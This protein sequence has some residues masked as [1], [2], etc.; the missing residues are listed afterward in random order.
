MIKTLRL[1][2]LF[3]TLA[4][5]VT[6]CKKKFDDYYAVPDGL[7]DPIYQTLQAKGNFKHYLAL[8]DRAGY[9]DILS[10]TGWF[11]VFAPDDAAFTKYFTDSGISTDAAISDSL[12]KG[13]VKFSLV[14]NGYR[15]DQLNIYQIAGTVGNP[16]MGYKR[17]TTYYDG[18]QQ[19][20]DAVH[21]KIIATNRNNTSDGKVTTVRYVDGDNNNKYIP[22][23]TDVFM[24]TNGLGASDYN[25]FYPNSAYS[26]FNVCGANVVNSDIIASN[27][28][29]HEIDRV[30]T[31]LPSIDQY[32]RLNANYSDFKLLMDSLAYYVA[33][34]NL[35]HANSV[36]TGSADSVYVKSYDGRLAYCIN[37]ENY[38]SGGS[39]I[40]TASQAAGWSILVPNNTALRAYRQKIL[41]KFGNSFFKTAPASVVIDFVNSLMWPSN[42][43]PSQFTLTNNYQLEPA[44][45][46]MGSI[47]DKQ[48]L[49]NGTFYGATQSQE[50]N[51]FRTVY[52]VQ[53]LDPK[54]SI[55]LQAYSS[56]ALP[57]KSQTTQPGVKNTVILMNDDVL[58]ANGWRY[59][60]AGATSATTT[61]WG[62][63]AVGST[64][65]SQSAVYRDVIFRMFQTGVLPNIDLTSLTGTGIV[66]TIN[67][68]FIKYNNGKIQ[69]S[70][71]LDAGVDL[72]VTQTNKT[73]VNGTAY[74]VDGML[75]FTNNNVGY[76]LQKLAAQYPSTY[77]SFYYYL[78][79]APNTLYN[80]TTQAI[81]GINTG[82]D[83]NYTVL[84]P[85]NAAITQAIKDGML[86]G[87][88]TTGA[89]PTAAPSSAADLDLVRK[90][91]L[92]HIINGSSLA[93]DQKTRQD[94]YPTL[95]QNES[96][97]TTFVGVENAPTSMTVI[98]R[99][100]KYI[101]VIL[102]A[103]SNQ[104]SNRTIIHS[105]DKYLHY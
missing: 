61:A 4:L 47:V 82:V 24:A 6:S 52:G 77:S 70:G 3:L 95:L 98:D 93:V 59:Y 16:G 60:E 22:Y 64:S 69:T 67:H 86:P 66:E 25:A 35:T 34:V 45:V 84:V 11:T 17:K 2:F 78:S 38:Q 63:K 85:T 26:G 7:G 48:I 89:L 18:I 32:I 21:K 33:N 13:I 102:G 36:A 29:I 53:Y 23:F 15:K 97:A 62:Y 55:I 8:V 56:G 88:K 79:T 43:W 31:P 71:T 10:A 81:A 91:I 65:Y 46:D 83:V 40:T 104:L 68:E 105:I 80:A 30:I 9:K 57:I 87:N 51:V 39:F 20:G 100:N 27:G 54:C 49:S 1:T 96:G 72:N 12:A 75:S 76:H 101:N 42:L 92:Y 41:S 50:A 14:Y 44:T 58:T 94:N 90:F 37:N 73:S 74:Y 5:A 103:T 19:K 28:I 99:T